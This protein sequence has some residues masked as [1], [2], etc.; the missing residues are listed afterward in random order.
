MSQQH[1]SRYF[2]RTLAVLAL[3]IGSFLFYRS[4][5]SMS[6]DSLY[7]L[8]LATQFALILLGVGLSLLETW[9]KR[10]PWIV[11]AVFALVGGIAM[12]AAV[13]QGQENTKEKNE[14]NRRTDEAQKQAS[15]SNAKLAASMDRLGAQTDEIK[16]VQGLN[17]ELQ[18]KLL[19]QNGQLIDSS[20]RI[21]DLS[22]QGIDVTT[23]GDSFCVFIAVANMGQGQP[24]K[25]PM[26]IDVIG[27]YPMSNVSAQIQKVGDNADINPFSAESV[28][29]VPLGNGPLLPGP[30]PIYNYS[31]GDGVYG[32]GIWSRN[33]FIA[34]NLTLQTVNGELTQRI[35]VY[36][37]GKKI[38]SQIPGQKPKTTPQ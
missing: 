23:G 36:R 19:D 38:Y 5:L 32:F 17:T 15:E 37:N 3:V 6:A 14:A 22:K 25:Y 21:T 26:F 33:G 2:V 8:N 13:R 16:R 1:V 35:E 28:P 4:M 12:F 11:L 10:H 20:K 30:H 31:L 29:H 9:P 7:Y 18:D 34:E 27:K 24:V